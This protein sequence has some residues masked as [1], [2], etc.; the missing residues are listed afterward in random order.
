MDLIDISQE[1]FERIEAYL[2]NT[3]S[4][5]DLLTFEKR[6]QSEEGLAAKVEEIKVVLTGIE[7]QSLKEQLDVFHDGLSSIEVATSGNEPKVRSLFRRRI[8]VAAAIIIAAGIFWFINGDS[9]E[10][11]YTKHFTPDPGLP[12]VMS[13]DNANFAFYD[14]MVNYKQGDY[15]LAISKWEKQRANSPQNDTLNYFIGSAYMANKNIT[16]GIQFL[17]RVLEADQSIFKS[18][19]NYYLGL[20]YLRNGDIDNAIKFL[21]L[22]QHENSQQVISEIKP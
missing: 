5:E 6:L 14:A 8:T 18:D 3:L 1:E 13:N 9:N 21:K 19:A 12:T 4:K 15:D 7:T 2:T 16:R 11:L 10:R 22:S 17:N 20:S